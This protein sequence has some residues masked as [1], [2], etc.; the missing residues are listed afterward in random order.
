MKVPS[1]QL[2]E[3]QRDE[4]QLVIKSKAE[5]LKSMVSECKK[6]NEEMTKLCDREDVYKHLKDLNLVIYQLF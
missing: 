6:C 3:Q 5:T 2:T 4:R 1:S